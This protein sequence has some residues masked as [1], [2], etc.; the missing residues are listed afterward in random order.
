MA[1]IQVPQLPQRYIDMGFFDLS[2]SQS[3]ANNEIS[4]LFTG[5]L[6]K[7]RQ[8]GYRLLISMYLGGRY[9]DWEHCT[10]ISNRWGVRDSAG[11]MVKGPDDHII[12]NFDN[13]AHDVRL[14]RDVI[15]P[16]RT[17][18]R[19]HIAA[20]LRGPKL[21]DVQRQLNLDRVQAF[22][23]YYQ[24]Q[25]LERARQQQQERD[26]ARLNTNQHGGNT[27]K[28]KLLYKKNKYKYKYYNGL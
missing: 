1:D 26:R 6:N 3:E 7:F 11:F 23:D 13:D 17:D 12:V 28:Y 24:R 5:R 9:T 21:D 10:L 16:T 4:L 20:R 27:N 15:D 19:V 14:D 2:E 18:H 22:K 8:P 25:Q